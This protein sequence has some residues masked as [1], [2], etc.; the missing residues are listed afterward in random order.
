MR[1]SYTM[2]LLGLVGRCRWMVIV[3]IKWSPKSGSVTVTR[4]EEGWQWGQL[5]RLTART[6]LL[7]P[8]VWSAQPRSAGS[9]TCR[10]QQ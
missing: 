4:H 7:L 3:A 8:S 9:M 2:P 1:A 6:R 5:S 10:L